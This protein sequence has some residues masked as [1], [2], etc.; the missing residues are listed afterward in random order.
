M[1]NIVG[2]IGYHAGSS[3]TV[4]LEANE[5]ILSIRAL[6]A[7]GAKLSIDGGDDIPIPAAYVFETRLDVEGEEF[8]GSTLVFTSTLS[9]FVKTKRRVGAT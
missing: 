2:K 7:S 9:Y 8:V 5:R 6:G 4:T 3:G 1:S